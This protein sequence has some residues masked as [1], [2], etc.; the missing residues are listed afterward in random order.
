MFAIRDVA[1]IRLLNATLL[2][3]AGVFAEAE[4]HV[5]AAAIAADIRG[6]PA[7][8]RFDGNGFCYVRARRDRHLADGS[9]GAEQARRIM[10]AS[11]CS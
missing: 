7:P 8:T 11:P 4:A 5:V 3:K 9:N 6:E 2:P 1:S 10:L